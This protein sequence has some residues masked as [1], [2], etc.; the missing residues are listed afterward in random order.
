ML[1]GHGIQEVYRCHQLTTEFIKRIIGDDRILGSKRLG[2]DNK[3]ATLLR[4]EYMEKA[5]D[6]G[7][8]LG[9][10]IGQAKLTL[11]NLESQL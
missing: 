10:N 2:G 6:T 1:R 11:A 5:I 3:D 7:L 9:R 8:V 4:I